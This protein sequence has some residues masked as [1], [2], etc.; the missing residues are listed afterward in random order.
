MCGE[1]HDATAT[2]PSCFYDTAVSIHA[3]LGFGVMV[4]AACG[5]IAAI[6]NYFRPKILPAVR[7]YLR[8]T[9]GAIALQAIIGIA[10]AATGSHPQQLLHW[11]YG[12][13]TLLTLPLAMFA[14]R[15]LG[16]RDERM[17]LAGG[18]ILTLLFTFRALATG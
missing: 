5:S 18:A 12:A 8:L 10:L 1:S 11:V 16:G 3:V 14:G 15:R 9:I 7:I 4:L 6:V 2:R 17:W 13:A